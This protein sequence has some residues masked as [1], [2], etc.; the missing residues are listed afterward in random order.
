MRARSRDNEMPEGL[1]RFV[2]AERPDDGGRFDLTEGRAVTD[3]ELLADD[4]PA[5]AAV[6]RRV[7]AWRRYSRARCDWLAERGL[8]TLME[9]RAAHQQELRWFEEL[10]QQRDE[11]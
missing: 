6:W 2:E 10:A 5:R 9:M 1:A 7:Y 4:P 3:D 11:Q 8:P